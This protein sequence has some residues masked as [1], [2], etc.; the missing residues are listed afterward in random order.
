MFQ[1][2]PSKF[3]DNGQHNLETWLHHCL[4]CLRYTSMLNTQT[5]AFWQRLAWMWSLLH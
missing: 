5:T 3:G 1:L 2:N 4:L